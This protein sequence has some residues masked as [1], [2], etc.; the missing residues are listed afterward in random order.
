MKKKK[1]TPPPIPILKVPKNATMRQ[2]LDR[3]REE[4]TAADLQKFTEI[5][6]GIPADKVLADLR[7]IHERFKPKKPRTRKKK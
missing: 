4:F 2:I 5:E 1:K 7:A 3:A 6:V